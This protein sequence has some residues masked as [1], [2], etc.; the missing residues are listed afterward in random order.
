MDN[1]SLWNWKTKKEE[2][3]RKKKK[4]IKKMMICRTMS[5]RRLYLFWLHD[6]AW[7]L[8]SGN[9]SWVHRYARSLYSCVMQV[10]LLRSDGSFKPAVFEIIDLCRHS[11]HDRFIRESG[12][13]VEGFRQ[14]L[15]LYR[16]RSISGFSLADSKSRIQRMSLHIGIS[17]AFIG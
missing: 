3:Q 10:S 11:V 8:P 4:Q 16:R 5:R 12:L 17:T 6:E 9:V 15:P 13:D 2:K 1:T 7:T 14:F